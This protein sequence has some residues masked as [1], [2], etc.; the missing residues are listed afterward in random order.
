MNRHRLV[1]LEQNNLAFFNKLLF[2]A[3]K[4]GHITLVQLT[5]HR[6]GSDYK[7]TETKM[8]GNQHNRAGHHEDYQHGENSR[9]NP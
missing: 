7:G 6:L 3:F 2:I 8:I 9:G 1:L 4:D 5:G